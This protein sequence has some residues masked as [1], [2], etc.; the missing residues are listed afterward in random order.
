MVNIAMG[1][2][3][4]NAFHANGTLFLLVARSS[5][6]PPDMSNILLFRQRKQTTTKTTNKMKLNLQQLLVAA[7]VLFCVL[8]LAAAQ[9]CPCSTEIGKEIQKQNKHQKHRFLNFC[10]SI[11]QLRVV[12][13]RKD[14]TSITTG[15][16]NS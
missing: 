11:Q 13:R 2:C 14:P 9:D 6:Y 3:Q 15:I 4:P 8:G 7:C 1:F 12:S 16:G 10:F 5:K